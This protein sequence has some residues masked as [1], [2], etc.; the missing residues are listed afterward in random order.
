MKFVTYLR[1]STE[2]Q[3]QSGLGLEAQRRA[4][5]DYVASVAGA[6]IIA[7]EFVE[8]ESGTKNQ[9]P[10]LDAALKLAKRHG[11]T[12]LIAKLDRLS[13]NVAFASGLLES[14]VDIVAVDMPH[15]NRFT[16]H[17]M[18]AVA[19]QE[20]R[21]IS[22][23]VKEALAA[24]KSRGVLLGSANPKIRSQLDLTAFAAQGAATQRAQADDYAATVKPMLDR[25]RAQITATGQ[26][27]TLGRI[28][29]GLNAQGVKTARGGEWHPTTV[30]NLLERVGA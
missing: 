12:L 15:A 6:V 2:R 10:K 11:A 20:A 3:G 8:I 7:P 17:V 22:I 18:A 24:A 16:M 1:V 29:D 4:V 26:R 14:G 5:A 13:R 30:K 19:E 9:R 28:A 27:V 25:I 23:R 21:A